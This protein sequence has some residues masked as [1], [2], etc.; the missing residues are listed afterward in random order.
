MKHGIPNKVIKFEIKDGLLMKYSSINDVGHVLRNIWL[1]V[2]NPS[3][4]K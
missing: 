3:L 4:D 2:E 1:V